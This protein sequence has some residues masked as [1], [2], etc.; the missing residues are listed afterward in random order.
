MIETPASVLRRH[1]LSARK[2]WGQHFLRDPSVH[3]AIVHAAA[4]SLHPPESSDIQNAISP[5]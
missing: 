1:G 3:A 4:R 5:T 2:Q